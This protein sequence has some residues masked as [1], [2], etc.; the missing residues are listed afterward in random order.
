MG[1]GAIEGWRSAA[2]PSIN[3]VVDGSVERSWGSHREI[4]DLQDRVGGKGEGQRGMKV[5]GGC[6]V[7]GSMEERISP[8]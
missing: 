4:Q 7:Q 5:S 6:S 1:G 8:C 2:A 3:P